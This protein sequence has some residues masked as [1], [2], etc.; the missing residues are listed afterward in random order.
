VIALALSGGAPAAGQ[1][2]EWVSPLPEFPLV[3]MAWDGQRLLAVDRPGGIYYGDEGASCLWTSADSTSWKRTWCHTSALRALACGGGT[4]VAVGLGVFSSTDGLSWTP[5]AE[6]VVAN[7]QAVTWTGN[8][9]VAVGRGAAPIMTSPDG[10]DWAA[11]QLPAGTEL[12]VVAASGGV[13]VIAGYRFLSGESVVLRSEDGA[14]WIP[15]ALPG[16]G[17]VS[18]I[19]WAGDRFLAIGEDNRVLASPDGASWSEVGQLPWTSRRRLAWNGSLLLAFWDGVWT[20]PDGVVWTERIPSQETSSYDIPWSAV[21]TGQKWV[22]NGTFTSA[23]GVS[24]KDWRFSLLAVATSGE[25]A[26]AAG[27]DGVILSSNNGVDWVRR[28]SPTAAALNSVT[29]TGERFVVAGERTVLA[30]PDGVTWQALATGLDADMR[31]VSWTGSR[32]EA[33]LAD[34]GLATSSDGVAWS[35]VAGAGGWVEDVTTAGW[36]QVAV[37]RGGLVLTSRD[38]VKWDRQVPPVP[39][40]L[41]GVTWNGRSFVAV[42][43]G[44]T[45]IRS[46]DGER[47]FAG[48]PPEP[49]V[50]EGSKL[51]R[52]EAVHAEGDLVTVWG[53]VVYPETW[54]F[55]CWVSS[56]GFSWFPGDALS[57]GGGWALARTAEHLT[58]VSG[59]AI[60]SQK[61]VPRRIVVPTSAHVSGING[62]FWRSELEVVNRGTEVARY[63]LALLPRAGGEVSSVSP[64]FTLQPGAAR[65]HRNLLQ[66]V[67]GTTGA[68]AV[69][70]TAL[71]GQVEVTSRTFTQSGS[72]SFGQAVP[73]IPEEEAA[74]AGRTVRLMGLS[75]AASRADGFRTNLGM[76]NTGGVAVTI[77]VT[78]HAASGAVLGT[79]SETVQAETLTQIDEVLRRVTADPVV[80]GYALLRTTTPGASFLAYASVI[81][82][83]TGDPVL[84]VAR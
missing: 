17:W 36:K 67:F 2:W 59:P 79:V 75:Q 37:G 21:W 33:V 70:V 51:D 38:G 84:I 31:R 54:G 13:T 34:G 3:G 9:F 73:G 74:T 28:Q 19:V 16:S 47:W 63:Q 65:R 32:H 45:L 53:K 15:T 72:G 56:D 64:R 35:R 82:N 80:G 1:G 39:A 50:L 23:D 81:D 7:L 5:R 18:A 41:L 61:R 14:T 24:W 69:R 27:G 68:G 44:P 62:T 49:P 6:G 46:P 43:A 57:A 22:V 8:R 10:I 71:V 11:I 55:R 40:D 42:G 52:L 25:T 30:S 26:V 12:D 58:L 76:V 77:D 60:M 66:E 29:W 20:S 83:R 4:C 78:L 48:K